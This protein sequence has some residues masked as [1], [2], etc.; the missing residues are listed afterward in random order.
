MESPEASS[1][2]PD[3]AA[4]PGAGG[5]GGQ[6]LLHKVGVGGPGDAPGQLD[7]HGLGGEE[8]SGGTA[9]VPPGQAAVVA[10]TVD[11]PLGPQC[12]F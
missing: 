4:G 5:P 10:G 6:A 11:P 8:G 12:H 9:Q 2:G 1:G 7:A 3:V